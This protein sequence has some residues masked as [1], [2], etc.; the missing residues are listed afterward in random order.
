[1]AVIYFV[2]GVS[3]SGKTTI[4][5]RLSELK[6]IP[7]FDADDFHSTE[8]KAKMSAGQPLNDEDRKGWLDTLNK[9]AIKQSHADGAVIACSALK[10]I[11]TKSTCR[12][13]LDRAY[14]R[15]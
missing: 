3:G 6:N 9:L 11:D 1:M 2:M 13:T 15:V 10:D 7:L 4:A 14:G 12:C 8:N 5:Q